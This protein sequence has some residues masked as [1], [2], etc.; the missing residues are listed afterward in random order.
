MSSKPPCYVQHVPSLIVFYGLSSHISRACYCRKLVKKR[1]VYIW[2][3]HFCDLALQWTWG[4]CIDLHSVMVYVQIFT[5]F[6]RD[7]LSKLI[8]QYLPSEPSIDE[9]V[10][11]L[12]WF[13]VCTTRP[14]VVGQ[15]MSMLSNGLTFGWEL[16]MAYLTN[17]IFLSLQ[18]DN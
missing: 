2:R 13:L 15:W 16:G 11:A 3:I 12:Y 10:I 14:L 9:I 1:T 6:I 18:N 17:P 7:S 8:L 5:F 4:Y